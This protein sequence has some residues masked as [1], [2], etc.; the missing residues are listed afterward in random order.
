[1][2]MGSYKFGSTVRIPLIVLDGGVAYTEDVSPRIK[3]IIKPNNSVEP[4]FP[5]PML[6]ANTEYG[7]YYFDY[8]PDLSGDYIV[9]MTSRPESEK[10][11]L[12]L[13]L[14]KLWI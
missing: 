2:A 8:T 6:T 1:M 7:T 3:E 9:L 14:K 5:Q 4:N 13:N 10:K 12:I 11:R